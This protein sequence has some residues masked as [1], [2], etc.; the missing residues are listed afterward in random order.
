MVELGD[1]IDGK[2]RLIRLLGKG[3]MGA[4]YEG[5]HELIDRRI[6]IKVLLPTAEL[7]QAVVRFEQEARAAGRIGNDHVLEVMDI[8]AMPDGSRYM[9]TEF[10]DGEPLSDRLRARPLTPE[11]LAPIIDQLLDGLS[12]A[13]GAG[14]LH[15][16]LKPDNIFLV[17]QKAGRRD[18]VKIIDF[19]I[20]K[21]QQLGADGMRMTA[22]GMVVGTPYYMSPEQA[23]GKG[24]VD[25]RSDLY[26]IGVIM[27]EALCGQVPFVAENFS[28][29]LFKVVLEEPPPLEQRV[30]GVDP[31]FIA[32]VK[33][34][35]ARA[36]EDR[37]QSA[38]EMRAALQPWL[39]G[40]Q[41]LAP[42]DTLGP[43]GVRA[44][45]P[46]GDQTMLVGAVA[47]PSVSTVSSSAQTPAAF[48][49][50][51]AALPLTGGNAAR[52]LPRLLTI[53]GALLMALAGVAL[54]AY[55]MLRVE[56]DT[57]ETAEITSAESI[58]ESTPDEATSASLAAGVPEAQEV[59]PLSEPSAKPTASSEA[60]SKPAP[61]SSASAT[62]EPKKKAA[63]PQ[64]AA[65][66]K[67]VIKPPK[68][69]RAAPP[70]RTPEPEPTQKRHQFGY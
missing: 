9:V 28:D 37:F 57:N 4:V 14:V 18:F 54:G 49:A 58:A 50:S 21:I 3:G 24:G 41:P 42:G 39:P 46:P 36:P 59:P 69:R 31:N 61:T 62:A 20:S 43:Q 60:V 65:P 10:L 56:G 12:A 2:Y 67:A 52:R 44:S 66:Q 35:M 26:S 15:R 7:E 1:V 11:E 40:A 23:R 27:Y 22:T 19:G 34:A 16:D 53:G 47:A 29:L 45:L 17:K 25:H 63:P 33:R 5:T 32:F 6:A 51:Q 70:E 8:G 38:E 64:P 13:H 55:L 30:Q 68:R 48:G